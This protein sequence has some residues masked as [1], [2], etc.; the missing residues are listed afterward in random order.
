MLKHFNPTTFK[1]PKM[2]NVEWND[3][4]GGVN[5]LFRETELKKNELAR[6]TNLI[7][8]GSG[9]PTKRWGTED[10]F[11]SGATGYGRG[12][13]SAKNT[14][15]TIELLAATDW[16]YLTKKSNASYS[17]ISGA[18]WPSGYNLE[19]TQLNGKVYIASAG[20]ELTR[21]DF[22]SLKNFATIATPTGIGISNFSGAT[23]NTTWSWRI[24]ATSELGETLGS[25]AQG[26]ASLPQELSDTT[27]YINWTPVSAAS[28]ILTGY[29][30]YRGQPGDETWVAGV[31]NESTEYFDKG[32]D[33][34]LLREPPLADTTGGPI[35]KYII[36][37][38]DRLILAGLNN[39]PTRVL[40]SGKAPS[41]HERFDWYGGGGYVYIDKDAGDHITGLA[42]HQGKLIV[43]K[44]FSIWQ[45]TLSTTK[46]GNFTILNPTYELITNSQ[47]C[48]SH[49][50]IVAVGN[51]LFF[52]GRRGIY[53]L[54]YEPNI[55]NVLRTNEISVKM[56]PFFEGLTETDRL[57]SSAAQFDQKYLI[58]FPSSKRCLLF[59][60]ERI[61]FMGPWN[62]SYGINCLINH[63]DA[64]GV[65][66][67]LGQDNNDQMVSKFS[68]NLKDDKGLAFSTVLKTR[69]EDFGDWRLFKNIQ[70]V[71]TEF[72]N[73]YGTVN[74]NVF[75]EQW[76]GLSITAKS[77]NITS[78]LAASGWGTDPWGTIQ[79]GLTLPNASA[80]SDEVIKRTKLFK[81]GRTF[82]LEIK[83]THKED[84]YEL[85][86]V[87]VLAIPQGRATFP[88]DD[89]DTS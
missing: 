77:L 47:G 60:R 48:S 18:S 26:Y 56:R 39:D 22:S 85:L 40:I 59:D 71:F 76:S 38:Q 30:V 9:V 35:A 52:L 46:Y 58:S 32:T 54:G 67:W 66:N 86:G 8:I 41:G 24:T 27:M 31:G 29:N 44:E 69:K 55:L 21:Y 17:T 20:R 72:R 61:A 43:F 19:M 74:M 16:G 57:N 89:W 65:E 34:A 51:D 75:L 12:L 84:N 62:M 73:V 78:Q 83:T 53:V 42:V 87:N 4:R 10:Y 33:A 88:V 50:T 11:L 6:G 5:Y 7:L 3:F 15:N 28:G 81:T 79:W 1:A 2:T 68:K 70:E 23:G 49:R 36:R 45:V 80:S 13:F 63:V 14:S 82:Q 25:V 64:N 37:Y